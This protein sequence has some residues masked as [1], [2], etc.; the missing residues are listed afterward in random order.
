M[1]GGQRKLG[2]ED[3][4]FLEHVYWQLSEV[5]GL[6]KCKSLMTMQEDFGI[7]RKTADRYLF[8]YPFPEKHQEARV[9]KNQKYENMKNTDPEKYG[10]IRKDDKLRYQRRMETLGKD[11]IKKT[12]Y[13]EKKNEISQRYRENLKNDPVAQLLYRLRMRDAQEKHLEKIKNDPAKLEDHVNKERERDRERRAEI[14]RN[15]EE[16]RE[17]REYKTKIQRRYYRRKKKNIENLHRKL[18]NAN[19]EIITPK[20]FSKAVANKLE[21]DYFKDFLKSANEIMDFFGFDDRIT[22][23]SLNYKERKLL[24][25]IE[26]ETGLVKTEREEKNLG[27]LGDYIY[28]QRIWKSNFWSLQ[29]YEILRNAMEYEKSMLAKTKKET[30]EEKYVVYDSNDIWTRN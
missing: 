5:W 1:G 8:L 22:D 17:Y 28:S 27:E 16:L 20:D 2:Q 15:P 10:K 19:H 14:R 6:S 21:N 26:K 23:N 9:H 29:K 3:I 11:P 13:R 30:K 24:Y 4:L 7:S 12:K 18:R 25:F